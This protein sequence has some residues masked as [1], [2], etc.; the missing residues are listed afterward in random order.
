MGSESSQTDKFK[1]AGAAAFGGEELGYLITGTYQGVRNS[2]NEPLEVLSLGGFRRLTAYSTDSLPTDEYVYGSA[3]VY[4]RLTS[5]DGVVNFPV[6]VGGLVEVADV[7]FNLLSTQSDEEFYSGSAYI[8]GQTPIGPV[9]FGAGFGEA[10]E[11][12]LF[13]FIGR[14]F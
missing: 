4:R 13:F 6:Y 7:G 8:G 5:T 10:G 9:F 12:S 2:E 3:E 11:K 14:S 1:L